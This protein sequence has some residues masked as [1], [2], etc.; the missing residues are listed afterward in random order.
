MLNATVITAW[1]AK[2]TA[3]TVIQFH[4]H[5]CYELV[6][7][8]YGSGKTTINQFS[9]EFNNN[10]FAFIK[11]NTLH[12]ENHLESGILICIGFNCDDMD[13][14]ID[15]KVYND[16][17]NTIFKIVSDILNESKEQDADYEDMLS[18]KVGELAIELRRMRDAPRQ[19]VKSLQFAKNYICENSSL[20]INFQNMASLCGYSY[21]YFHHLFKEVTGY[22]PQQYLIMQRLR[23]S[24]EMLMNSRQNC[25][26]IA[27]HCGFSNSAQ[28]SSLFKKEFGITP[29]SYQLKEKHT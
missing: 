3:G 5:S 25:T 10:Q 18:L 9:F 4:K 17:D 24:K 22:S 29:K 2:K 26:E 1:K 11:P 21:D 16:R 6:Y 8:I 27:Y 20:K 13:M 23:T 28:F 19:T 12:N 15:E 7:Y 14:D